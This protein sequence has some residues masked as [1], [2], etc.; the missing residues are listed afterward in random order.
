VESDPTTTLTHSDFQGFYREKAL[1]FA[2]FT[3]LACGLLY[4]R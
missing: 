4:S 3:A 2:D 1:F